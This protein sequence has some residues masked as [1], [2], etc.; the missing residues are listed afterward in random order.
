[1]IL[2][3]G[4]TGNVGRELVK[5]LLDHGAQVRILVRDER[6]ANQFGNKA[7]IAIGDLDQPETLPAALRGV[8]RLYFVTPITSQVE[9]LLKAARQAGV[10]HVVKQSTIEADRSLGPGKWHREQ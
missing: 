9:N 6:K 3:S 2:V 10:R 7:E 8:E 1:M 5:L 4:A